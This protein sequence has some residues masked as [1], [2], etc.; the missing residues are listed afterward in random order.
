MSRATRI[1][2]CQ[3]PGLEFLTQQCRVRTEN[4]RFC[5]GTEVLL[6]PPHSRFNLRALRSQEPEPSKG[7]WPPHKVTAS[8]G[9][10]QSEGPS[11]LCPNTQLFLRPQ[12][13]QLG[14]PGGWEEWGGSQPSSAQAPGMNHPL[15]IRCRA[16]GL[17][18]WAA[19]RAI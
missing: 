13:K 5:Q 6:A 11:L 15:V 8:W 19:E 1:A 9:Q 14:S 16:C 10:G 18:P 2:D 7:K 3:D 4:L 17:S 12:A